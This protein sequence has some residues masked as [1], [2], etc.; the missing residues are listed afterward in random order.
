MEEDF[1]NALS[2]AANK[3]IKELENHN[4]VR[5]I[6]HNDCDGIVSASILIKALKKLNK[7]FVVSFVRNLT[8]DVLR[9]ITLENYNIIVFTDL[10]SGYL[11]SINNILN[12]KNV[13]I[14]DHHQ[15]KGSNFG[16][17]HINPLLYNVDGETGISA[18]GVVYL[19]TKFIDTNNKENAYLAVMGAIGDTQEYKGFN[20]L[21]KKILED[22]KD[23]LEIK[24]GLRVFGAQTRAIQKVLEYSTDVFIPGV[25]GDESGSI[26]FLQSLDIEIQDKDGKYRK[27]INLNNEEMERLVSAIVI[28]RF[29][30]SENAEDVLGNIY[31]VKGENDEEPTRD[32]REFSTLLNAT[33]K[34]NK[35]S[36]GLGVCL[37]DKEMKKRAFDLLNDYKIEII[38]S[39]NWFYKN[40]KNMRVIERESYVIINAEEYIKD[41]LIGTI[42]SIISK[43]VIYKN[44]TIII[45]MAHTVDGFTKISARIVGYNK[46][47]LREILFIVIQKVGGETGGH[48]SA[49]GAL[50]LQ[51]KD[52][53]FI[54]EVKNYFEKL[55]Q[56][57]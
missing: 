23:R 28:R 26:N 54:E 53:Y 30:K 21:N 50:I 32:L 4:I 7:S 16:G 13:F 49:A 18:A 31:L 20:G 9:E 39:L 40:K 5:I 14:L 25:T 45:A 3:F 46:I 34:L 15:I 11:D 44:G 17:V 52:N 27:L 24:T 43:S 19:F 10:G 55:E 2:E 57:V 51:E 36:I 56:M 37:N 12:K 47:N 35:P 8:S 48:D 29:N 33:A 41:T 6:S 22:S 42:A 1:F 38:N